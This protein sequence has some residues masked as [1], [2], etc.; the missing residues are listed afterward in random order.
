MNK[1]KINNEIRIDGANVVMVFVQKRRLF[2]NDYICVFDSME[3][4]ELLNKF[5]KSEIK[6]FKTK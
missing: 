1:N 5:I 6:I 2:G 3:D 4:V